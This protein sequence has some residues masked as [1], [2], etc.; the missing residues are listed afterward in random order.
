MDFGRGR[1]DILD[2]R[3]GGGLTQAL[4]GCRRSS[5]Q[6]DRKECG[7]ARASDNV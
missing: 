4:A 6:E 5:E 3:R 2:L 7:R 1:L